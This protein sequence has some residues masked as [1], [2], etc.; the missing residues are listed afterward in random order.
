[1]AQTYVQRPKSIL[2]KCGFQFTLIN[3]YDKEFW[4]FLYQNH[5]YGPSTV[6]KP[7]LYYI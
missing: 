7:I 6:E 5:F 3:I 4:N 1:M 2:L